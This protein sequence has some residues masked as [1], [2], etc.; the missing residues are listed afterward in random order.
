[1]NGK[2]SDL[3]MEMLAR[4][5]TRAASGAAKDIEAEEESASMFSS[6]LGLWVC[7]DNYQVQDKASQ[8]NF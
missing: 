7:T 3:T 4:G 1:M 5:V 8:V 6:D 2:D